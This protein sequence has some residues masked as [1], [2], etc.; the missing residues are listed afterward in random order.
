MERVREIPLTRGFVAI[1][2][3]ADFA[4]AMEFVWVAR[5]N[6]R[7]DRPGTLKWYASCPK[8]GLL[9]RWLMD[10]P[11]SLQVDHINGDSLDCR[12]AN[13]RLCTV[14]ENMRNRPRPAS[15]GPGFKGVKKYKGRYRAVIG[16]ESR[17]VRLG[18]YATPEEAAAAYDEAARRLHGEFARLNFPEKQAA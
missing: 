12:R 6:G 8:I 5:P 4:R 14:S 18:S 17:Q 1:V 15:W 3:A 16:F 11:K 9:H 10:A 7:L 2:D 13:M